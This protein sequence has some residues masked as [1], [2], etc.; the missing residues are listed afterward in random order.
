MLLE[1]RSIEKFSSEQTQQH[2]ADFSEK[3]TEVDPI[4]L[5]QGNEL[6]LNFWVKRRGFC[7]EM[8]ALILGLKPPDVQNPVDPISSGSSRVGLPRVKLFQHRFLL[9]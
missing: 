5:Q 8:N 1:G 7:L 3:K 2:Q 4:V 6:L 9:T